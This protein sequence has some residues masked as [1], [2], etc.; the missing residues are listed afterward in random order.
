MQNF[1]LTDSTFRVTLAPYFFALR[2]LTFSHSQVS[3]ANL[4]WYEQLNSTKFAKGTSNNVKRGY[5]IRTKSLTNSR[6]SNFRGG[7][8]SAPIFTIQRI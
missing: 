2:D 3:A 7:Y 1:C 4:K 8:Y 6:V 5:Y